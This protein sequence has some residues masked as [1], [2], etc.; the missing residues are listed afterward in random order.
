MV[1][2]SQ[3]FVDE[4]VAHA[5]A[6]LPNECC[7]I[8]AGPDGQVMR[9]YRITNVEASPYRFV[10]D[11]V[12]L[13]N[14]DS[15]AGDNDWELLAIYHSHTGSE[16]YPSD[17]DVRIAGDTAGLYP[18]VRY[19]LVSLMDMD[20]PVVRIFEITDGTVTEEPLKRTPL[21]RLIRTLPRGLRW[22]PAVFA[23]LLI[24]SRCWKRSK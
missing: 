16:A 24:A 14:V 5:K 21:G 23:F 6:D 2:I 18:D 3:E 19:V 20:N 4:M 12:E 1:Q 10:M 13:G 15:D 11:P 9:A 17:T 8:L 22:L 7:G